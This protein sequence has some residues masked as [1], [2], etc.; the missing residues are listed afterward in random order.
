MQC[1]SLTTVWKADIIRVIRTNNSI[2]TKWI[3]V[4]AQLLYYEYSINVE[5]NIIILKITE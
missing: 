3:K 1:F 5:D 2:S 4:K